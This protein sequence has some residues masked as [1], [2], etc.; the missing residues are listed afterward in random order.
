[1]ERTQVTEFCHEFT[2]YV[3]VR[4]AFKIIICHF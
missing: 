3:S 2:I 1:M 4:I